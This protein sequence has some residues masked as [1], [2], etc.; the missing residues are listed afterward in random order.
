MSMKTYKYES[1]FS[2]EGKM[3]PD[4]EDGTEFYLASDV[5]ALESAAVASA[6]RV[7]DLESAL[8]ELRIRLHCAGR[9]PEECYEMHMIDSALTETATK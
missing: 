6:L 4:A 7:R 9:R 1:G 3:V 8:R 5:A 2:H